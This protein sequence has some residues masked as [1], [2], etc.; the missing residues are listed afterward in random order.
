MK[1]AELSTRPVGLPRWPDNFHNFPRAFP[2][3][4]NNF[5]GSLFALSEA[6]RVFPAS[7]SLF[8]DS[9]HGFPESF[10]GFLKSFM[11]PVEPFHGFLESFLEPVEWFMDTD[12]SFTE[13]VFCLKTP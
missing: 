6:G 5:A 9:F 12:K 10:N 7:F 2:A 4:F 11:E 1:V 13:P 3:A 8:P